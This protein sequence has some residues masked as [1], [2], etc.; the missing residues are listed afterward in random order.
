MPIGKLLHCPF[1]WQ[2]NP[3]VTYTFD[4]Q[5]VYVIFLRHGLLNSK[6]STYIYVYPGTGGGGVMVTLRGRGEGG[7]REMWRGG[8]GLFSHRLSAAFIKE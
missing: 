5:Y 4:L 3:F 2:L 6:E 8:A 7:G 1:N